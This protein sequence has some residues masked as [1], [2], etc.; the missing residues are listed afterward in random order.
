MAMSE[1][2]Q[3]KTR[4]ADSRGEWL[5]DTDSEIVEFSGCHFDRAVLLSGRLYY[6]TNFVAGNA[7]QDK[8]PEFIRWAERVFRATKESLSYSSEMMAYVGQDAMVWRQNGGRFASLR[9]ADGSYL[10]EAE[11]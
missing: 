3:I 5:L 11:R 1:D 9:R 8:S 10:F 6:Q 4:Y 7:F 2:A